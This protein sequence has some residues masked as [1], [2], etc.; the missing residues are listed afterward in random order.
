M[1]KSKNWL[2]NFIFIVQW[3]GESIYW[4]SIEAILITLLNQYKMLPKPN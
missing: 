1:I 2:N 3:M 4:E